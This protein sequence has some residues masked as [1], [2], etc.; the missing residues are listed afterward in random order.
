MGQAEAAFRRTGAMMEKYDV[1]RPGRPGGGGEY[2]NQEGFGWTNAVV[3]AFRA[4]L[5]G[6]PGDAAAS[7]RE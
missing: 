1:R 7:V 5:R 2:A 4:F 3:C 6:G